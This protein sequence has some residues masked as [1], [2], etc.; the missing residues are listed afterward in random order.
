M[1]MRSSLRLRARPMLAVV[2]LAGV[3]VGACSKSSPSGSA[4][5]PA[6]TTGGRAAAVPLRS[7]LLTVADLP[8]GWKA[9][10]AE[11]ITTDASSDCLPRH[12]VSIS[13]SAEADFEGKDAPS[14]IGEII[15]S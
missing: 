6:N 11:P 10:P 13:P 5:Q 3:F 4:N 1:R 8:A 2:L 9:K 15:A 14:Q 7:L 12:S